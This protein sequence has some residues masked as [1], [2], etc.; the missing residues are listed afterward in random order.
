MNENNLLKENHI[1]EA[2]RSTDIVYLA[3]VIFEPLL[4]N[5]LT[6]SSFLNRDNYFIRKTTSKSISETRCAEISLLQSTTLSSWRPVSNWYHQHLTIRWS[7]PLHREI[8]V[9][10]LDPKEQAGAQDAMKHGQKTLKYQKNIGSQVM[11]WSE[12]C[13]ALQ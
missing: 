3:D 12:L 11:V 2:V 13:V 4:S 9:H 6:G 1:N 8:V 5:N 10:I 7:W